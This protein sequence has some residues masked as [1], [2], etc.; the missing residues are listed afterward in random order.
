MTR[1]LQPVDAIARKIGGSAGLPG[2]RHRGGMRLLD[3]CEEEREK[4]N[5]NKENE[6][7]PPFHAGGACP[8]DFVLMAATSHYALPES[9]PTTDP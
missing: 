9:V 4:K 3:G 7:V 2:E 8:A 6:E 1:R 5:G